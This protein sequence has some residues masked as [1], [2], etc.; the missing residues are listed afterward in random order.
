MSADPTTDF[1]F[2]RAC[3]LAGREGFLARMRLLAIHCGCTMLEAKSIGLQAETMLDTGNNT[4]LSII[5]QTR[6]TARALV[7]DR[8]AREAG[9]AA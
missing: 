6:D 4:R 8:R 5:H 9:V 1:I 3:E 7:R 2:L